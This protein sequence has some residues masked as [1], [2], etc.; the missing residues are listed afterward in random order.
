M[1]GNAEKTLRYHTALGGNMR[2]FIKILM[3]IVLL[4]LILVSIWYFYPDISAESIDEKDRYDIAIEY[5]NNEVSSQ[6]LLYGEDIEFR[7]AVNYT[8]ISA[9]DEESI[10]SDA[11]Y[12][13]LI[14]SDLGGKAELNAEMVTLLKEY[15]DKNTSFNF[16]Y[17]GT[18]KLKIFTSGIFEY[19][20]MAEDEMSF[21]YVVD[22][23]ERLTYG[24][25]W[26]ENDHQYLDMNREL[27]QE[28]ILNIIAQIIKSNE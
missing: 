11:D 16:F 9:I 10:K 6:L 27:L 18:D 17:I 22:K 20:G 14:I 25:A 13:Y 4:F 23:G 26:S 3:G 19:Y 12:V 28:N 21:G 15:A 24:G 8:K 5:L 7:E 1:Y 2:K